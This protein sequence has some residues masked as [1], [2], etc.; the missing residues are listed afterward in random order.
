MARKG[1]FKKLY[2]DLKSDKELSKK[3]LELFR[4]V[5]VECSI[6]KI[7]HFF[8]YNFD[9]KSAVE[10]LVEWCKKDVRDL[11]HITVEDAEQP[12]FSGKV[13]RIRYF[14]RL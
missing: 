3:L 8:I 14:Q 1:K 10:G 5:P 7:E 13:N 4:R 12:V 11:C 9:V 2:E 6:A